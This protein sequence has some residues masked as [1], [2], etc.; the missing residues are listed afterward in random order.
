M[1]K[2]KRFNQGG[3]ESNSSNPLGTAGK[4]GMAAGMT[5]AVAA[6]VV[7][8]GKIYKD[9]KSLGNAVNSGKMSYQN[10]S[11]LMDKKATKVGKIAGK[12]TKAGF[13]TAGLGAAAWGAS[14]L[15]GGNKDNR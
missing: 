11:N 3:Q 7:G 8:I 2:I 10:A 6:P 12:A 5:T 4:V 15:M 14:K 1:Y 9:A 13:I